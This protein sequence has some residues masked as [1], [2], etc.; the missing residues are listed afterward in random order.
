[1]RVTWKEDP[2]AVLRGVTLFDKTENPQPDLKQIEVEAYDDAPASLDKAPET[3]EVVP[4]WKAADP[5]GDELVFRVYSQREGR[6]EWMPLT[7][8]PTARKA[9]KW[10]T[11]QAANGCYRLKVVA[12][13]EPTNPASE[14]LSSV[15]VTRPTLVDNRKPTFQ[16]LRR[17]RPHDRGARRGRGERR[18]PDRVFPRRR[19]LAARPPRRRSPRRARRTLLDHAAAGERA[20]RAPRHDPR[21]RRG[22]QRGRTPGVSDA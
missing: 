6:P 4:R 16:D 7:S 22:R 19:P 20:G 21:L 18:R 9:F 3:S 14:A 2:A 5:N 11:R 10:D 1:V 17:K 13:D 8:E 15:R 12:S